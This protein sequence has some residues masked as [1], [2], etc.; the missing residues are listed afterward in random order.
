MIFFG[1]SK[2]FPPPSCRLPLR[3]M[4]FG[5]KITHIT[6]PPPLYMAA[7]GPSQPPDRKY[8]RGGHIRG[9]VEGGIRMFPLMLT[10]LLTFCF[11]PRRRE[12]LCFDVCQMLRINGEEG[13]AGVYPPNAT[14]FPLKFFP[15]GTCRQFGVNFRGYPAQEISA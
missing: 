4:V 9:G 3:G 15:G 13:R 8:R 2:L 12:L 7:P 11:S 14:R 1:F 10:D 5:P 6:S